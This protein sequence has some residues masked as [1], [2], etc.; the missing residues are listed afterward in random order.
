MERPVDIRVYVIISVACG[1]PHI[2]RRAAYSITCNAYVID[3]CS[4]GI[5]VI[6]F[7]VSKILDVSVNMKRFAQLL[8]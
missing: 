4:I 8:N 6:S 5:G 7:N 1:D 3:E 2:F